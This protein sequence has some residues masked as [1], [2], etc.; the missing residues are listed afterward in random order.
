MTALAVIDAAVKVAG[1]SRS[2]FLTRAALTYIEREAA[3]K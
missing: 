3:R 2:A 1:T